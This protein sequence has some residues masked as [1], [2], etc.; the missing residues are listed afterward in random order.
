M[1]IELTCTLLP[2][3][4]PD[5][6]PPH[7]RRPPPV[8][9]RT[10]AIDRALTSAN[11]VSDPLR[12]HSQIAPSRRECGPSWRPRSRQSSLRP[13]PSSTG[14]YQTRRVLSA[15]PRLA[16]PSKCRSTVESEASV[17]LRDV[18]ILTRR[19]RG[20]VRTCRGK[21]VAPADPGSSVM[22]IGKRPAWMILRI[23]VEDAQLDQEVARRSD[24]E[25]VPASHGGEMAC[26]VPVGTDSLSESP[27]SD[28]EVVSA[29]R[30]GLTPCDGRRCAT[31]RLSVAALI[32]RAHQSCSGVR[33][34][35][36]HHPCHECT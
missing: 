27:S 13:E 3:S 9:A 14:G 32:G 4:D 24:G 35:G 10:A 31:E 25:T 15:Q 34:T 19:N 29:R 22:S 11:M 33:W 12:H 1:T 8:R 2:L 20:S 6:V 21:P 36:E 28:G 30:V 18:P 5:R 23:G 26:A 17:L 7:H 16:P